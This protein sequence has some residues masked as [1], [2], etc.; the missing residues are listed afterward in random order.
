MQ[1]VSNMQKTLSK[2]EDWLYRKFLAKKHLQ[3]KKE[4]YDQGYSH[5]EGEIKYFKETCDAHVRTIIQE[6]EDKISQMEY[7]QEQ[8]TNDVIE[9]WFVDPT[10][11]LTITKTGLMMLN[12]EQLGEREINNYKSE[13]RTMKSFMIYDIIM[14]TVRQKANEKA[15]LH[16]NASNY[17][18]TNPDLLAGKM[19]IFN[20]DIVKTIIDK[21]DNYKN[22]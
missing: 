9:S 18:N 1:R 12:G 14:N 21:I 10:K 15:I 2:I 22:K 16:S 11:V 5:A 7:L 6:C 20:L 17:V 13:V 19:M 3:W 4:G 8:R